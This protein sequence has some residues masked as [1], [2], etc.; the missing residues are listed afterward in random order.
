MACAGKTSEGVAPTDSD[1]GTRLEKGAVAPSPARLQAFRKTVLTHY[2]EHARDLPWRRTRDPYAI[3]VSEV[4]LQQTQVVRVVPKYELFLAAFPTVIVLARAPVADVL[5]AWQGLGYN[6]RALALHRAAGLIASES[7]GTVPDSPAELTRLPGVGAA[8]AAAV[9][10]FAYD[11]PLPFIETNIRSAFIHFFFQEGVSVRDADI[12]PLV[13]ATLD[14]T[15]PRDWY[16]A[17]MDY[18]ARVKKSFRNPSRRSLHHTVQSP[19]AGSHRQLRAMVLRRLL[20][21][22]PAPMTVSELGEL[23][24]GEVDEV[25]ISG[26]LEELATEGFLVREGDRYRVA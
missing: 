21:V 11:L 12:L 17:L 24:V 6:R 2:R 14:R 25:A 13:E 20:S 23:S 9:C 16:Y 8:T 10:V 26:V 19:F 18:G 1:F 22:A 15:N 5:S 4:M 7:G 3:L